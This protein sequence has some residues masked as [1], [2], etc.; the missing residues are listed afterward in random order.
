[1]AP[2]VQPI[3]RELGISHSAMGSVL[4]PLAIGVLYDAT[5]G[6]A[7][8]L[9]LLTAICAVLLLPLGLLRRASA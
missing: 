8:A 4:G 5:G 9:Y 2:L 3:I 6:F 7:M 1:M